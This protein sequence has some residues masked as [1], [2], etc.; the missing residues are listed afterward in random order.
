MNTIQNADA[1]ETNSQ[2]INSQLLGPAVLAVGKSSDYG[3]D[4]SRNH[5]IIKVKRWRLPANI[6]LGEKIKKQQQWY[7]KTNY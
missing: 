4:R 5:N 1:D 2:Q 7:R 6:R 3:G